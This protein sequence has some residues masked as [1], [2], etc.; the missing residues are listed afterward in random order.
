M[1]K[2]FDELGER[3]LREGVAPRHIR[4]Y[5]RE[6][7]DHL[8][9]LTAEEERR[10]LSRA[11]AEAAALARLGGVEA[12]ASAIAGQRQFRSWRARA[13]WAAFGLTPLV[14]LGAT[15]LAACAILWSG[16][17]ILLPGTETPFVR[18]HGFSGFY[19]GVGR[20][21]YFGAPVLVGWGIGL[22]AMRQRLRAVWPGVGLAMVAWIGAAVR[23][24]ASRLVGYE[25]AGR[26]SITLAV[27]SSVGEVEAG[28]IHALVLLALA[29]APYV[30]WCMY[31][32][33]S[34]RET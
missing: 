7:A 28:L 9:D 11:E 23:V 34:R 6:L 16:W 8:A 14:L 19:F 30:F 18:L 1:P 25:G 10:G 29:G 13:P 12:L 27:G 17:D 33:W 32:G 3:L 22:A 26:V 2:P 15:Y 5:L 21:L 24:H 31:E 20:L 4:R